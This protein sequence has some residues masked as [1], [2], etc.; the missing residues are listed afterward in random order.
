MSLFDGKWLP[1]ETFELDLE[2]LRRGWY[3]DQ[4]FNNIVR[5]LT[6]LAEEGYRFAGRCPALE[7]QGIDVG[8]V[9]V[10]DLEVDMQFF[11]RRQPFTILAGMDHA[12]A[13]LRE[14]TGYWEKAGGTG[15]RFVNTADRLE[16][17]AQRDGARVEP[18]ETVLRVRGRYR[19]FAAL[20]TVLLGALSR[21]SRIATNVYRTLRASRGK[22][23]LFFPARFD[24]P[25]TQASD[26]YAY[27]IAVQRYNYETGANVPSF[28]STDAQGSWWG[29]RGVGT[30]AHAYI[31]SF[32]RDTATAMLEFARIMP[33]EVRRIALVDTN[34]D[35]VGD[36]LATARALFARYRALKRAGAE[37]EAKKYLLFGVRPDTASNLRDVSLEP[38]GTPELDCGVN[39]RLVWALRRALDEEP[40]RLNLPPE[41]RAEAEAYFR[42]VK[43]IVSGG[44][45][46]KRIERFETLGVP[47]DMYGV[48]STYF[49]GETNDFTADVV[50]VKI[51]GVWHDLAKVGRQARDHP[52]LE[53]V[54]LRKKE[55]GP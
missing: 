9:A 53:T 39:P 49:S 8:S 4:Y 13:I 46:A 52:A 48:G 55:A 23:I 26:G 6:R 44:F 21:G 10:G 32:L 40:A 42:N 2:R 27:H 1:S 11:T 33:V 3:T 35:C 17:E 12:L 18:W 47:V 31:L 15:E 16:V 54:E 36:S 28:V 14:C 34:N 38:L 45:N 19:D 41:E 25:A 7:E 43:I 30:V 51:G 24:L 29:G 5:I 22:P 50:R 37:E 20:E